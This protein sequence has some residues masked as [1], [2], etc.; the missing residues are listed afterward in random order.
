MDEPLWVAC[1]C[2]AWCRLCDDY[3]AVFEGTVPAGVRKAWIDIEDH[4]DALD[5]VD[6]DNFPTLLIARGDEL[7]FL[8]TIE[9][10][11]ATLARLVERA[12]RGLL[13]PLT[14]PHRLVPRLRTALGA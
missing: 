12:Q 7:L 5:D 1:L 14:D 2:A 3:G 9:P 6:I 13:P 10:Q 8:G 4:A 11:P